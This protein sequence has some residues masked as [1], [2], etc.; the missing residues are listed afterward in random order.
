MRAMITLVVC[1]LLLFAVG[2][3]AAPQRIEDRKPSTQE[4]EMA[5]R[6]KK[7]FN[8]QR[9]KAIAADAEKILG[10]AGQIK[11]GVS[12]DKAAP[13][14]AVIEKLERVEKLAHRIRNNMQENA[15]ITD[16]R[17]PA[18]GARIA[19]KAVR[20]QLSQSGF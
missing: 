17:G 16:A 15:N 4:Q 8:K 6:R 20:P 14:A 19:K 5:E 12:A 7:E 13:S 18:P 1:F 2:E 9:H 3:P 10:L 11:D